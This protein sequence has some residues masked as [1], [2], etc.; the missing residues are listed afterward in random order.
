MKHRSALWLVLL[1]ASSGCALLGKGKPLTVRY[2]DLEGPET[3]QPKTPA[4]TS[5]QLRL[6][7]VSA[8][9]AIDRRFA[10]RE[11]THELRYHDGLRFTDQPEK[12]LARDLGQ[13]LFERARVTRVV[14]GL[15]PTLEVQLTAFEQL[16][17][18]HKVHVAALALMHDDRVQFWQREFTGELPIG[19]GDSA[20]AVADALSKALAQVAAQI[21]EETLRAL[22]ARPSAQ[23]EAQAQV[24]P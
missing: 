13:N 22:S 20:E 12:F 9:R 21:T 11:S 24:V 18:A 14:S 10:S 3:Y 8:V 2:F 19:H 4:T 23:A 6:G 1:L 7:T 17:E 5:T 15:A 16:P